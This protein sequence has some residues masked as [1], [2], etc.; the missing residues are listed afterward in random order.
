[1]LVR[2]LVCRG[3]KE[4]KAT[5]TQRWGGETDTIVENIKTVE[6]DLKKNDVSVINE[7]NVPEGGVEY[8]TVYQTD[9]TQI[10]RTHVHQVLLFL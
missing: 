5:R 3:G 10:L 8:K 2:Y 4:L 1:M 7:K 6:D 9:N